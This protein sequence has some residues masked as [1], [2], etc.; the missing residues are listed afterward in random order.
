MRAAADQAVDW[1]PWGEEAFAR[2]RE[3]ARPVLLD[4][5]ASW[6]HFCHVMD[7]E[8][9]RDPEIASYLNGNYVAVRVDAD[10]RPDLDARYQS[11]VAQ[12]TG[13][14]GWPLTAFLAPTERC[15]SAEPTFR[16]APR[17]RPGFLQILTWARELYQS[18]PES[19]LDD[20]RR[21][22]ENLA[23]RTGWS[24][25]GAADAQGAIDRAASDLVDQ[26]DRRNGG[27]GEFPKS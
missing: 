20:G 12:L 10:E 24:A 2:A 1:F 18:S 6:C 15:T 17:G 22:R 27:F 3:L 7:A 23:A 16:G 19:R 8:C 21:L 14:S 25:G 4:I 5:G 26:V 9:Y 11:A 13:S